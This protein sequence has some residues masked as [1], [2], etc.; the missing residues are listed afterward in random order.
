MANGWRNG[1]VVKTEAMW[2]NDVGSVPGLGAAVPGEEGYKMRV[3]SAA[4]SAQSPAAHDSNLRALQEEA[5]QSLY[6]ATAVASLGLVYLT[7]SL[8]EAWPL[9]LLGVGLILVLYPL[10]RFL[11]RY[12][13][14]RAWALAG[15]WLIVVFVTS[16]AFPGT[17]TPSLLILPVALAWLLVSLPAGFLAA[18][19]LSI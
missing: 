7:Y 9:A 19:G 12:Y 10:Q 8:P 15:L 2:C 13:L 18:F 5:L 4:L 17:V 1:S 6:V 11:A 14:V 16:V 3:L